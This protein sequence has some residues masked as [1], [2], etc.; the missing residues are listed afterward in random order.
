MQVTENFHVPNE[1]KNRNPRTTKVPKIYAF[2][3][4]ILSSMNLGKG[5]GKRTELFVYI[6]LAC[7]AFS[8]LLISFSFIGMV[9]ISHSYDIGRCSFWVLAGTKLA[10]QKTTVCMV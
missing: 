1:I 7:R 2:N 8:L 4:Q 6:T 3:P 5:H 10:T 9:S